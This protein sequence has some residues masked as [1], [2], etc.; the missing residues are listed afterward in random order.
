MILNENFI[1][2]IEVFNK[3]KVNYVLVGGW[4]VVF[5]G[6]E[7]VTGDMDLLVEKTPENAAG[8]LTAL[9]EFWGSDLGFVLEDFLKD[10]NVLMMGR[11]PLRID[12]LTSISGVSFEEVYETSVL[13]QDGNTL[14]RCIHINELIRNKEASGRLKDLADAEKLKKIREKR[15]RRK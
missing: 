1:E 12:L 15:N 13:Y 5:E 9:R 2:F 6:Y 8:I 14:I 3:H 10:D 7:R 4:A 11:P